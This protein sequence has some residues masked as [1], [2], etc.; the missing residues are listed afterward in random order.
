MDKPTN[1]THN[2]NVALNPTPNITPYSYCWSL[3]LA[4][5]VDTFYMSA[6]FTIVHLICYNCRFVEEFD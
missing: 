1:L 6:L 4:R 3:N 5:H 2:A